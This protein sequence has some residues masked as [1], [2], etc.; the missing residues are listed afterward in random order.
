MEY[1]KKTIE[2]IL[3]Q[4]LELQKSGIALPEIL[5]RFPEHHAELQ[6]LLGAAAILRSESKRIAP[7]TEF[8]ERPFNASS[9]PEPI[10]SAIA[11]FRR[12]LVR[13]LIAVPAGVAVILFMLIVYSQT[14][15][16]VLPTVPTLDELIQEAATLEQ[17]SGTR[18][19][20]GMA[21]EKNALLAPEPESALQQFTAPPA[22]P[23]PAPGTSETTE[24]QTNFAIPPSAPQAPAAVGR[25]SADTVLIVVFFP[26]RAFNP[27]AE[28]CG[29]V[30]AVERTVP[31]TIGTARA[32]IEELLRGTTLDEATRG[33]FTNMNADVRVNSLTIKNGLA[34]VDLSEALEL[35]V[36]G[37]CRVTSI[38]AQIEQTLKQFPTVQNV[39]IS[40]NGR[41]QDILQP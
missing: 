29:R 31:K 17:D 23:A 21:R 6:E 8:A 32:A 1:K 9:T 37:S 13:T 25:D 12:L 24:F 41:T 26:N 15:S 33:Y 34:T 18:E 4:A 16:P 5:R 14:K 38:R 3:D 19:A 36:G 20:A 40:I 7:S 27:N 39:I 35:G 30:F 11:S 22:A 10:Q 2:H 28:D